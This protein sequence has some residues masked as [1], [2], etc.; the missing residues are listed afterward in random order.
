MF[1]NYLLSD[2]GC[3]YGSETPSQYVQLILR[4][5]RVHFLSQKSLFPWITFISQHQE[6]Q[7]P[8]VSLQGSVSTVL[9]KSQ[10]QISSTKL[11]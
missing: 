2:G 1:F 7:V 6:T 4:C 8:F 3:F 11:T 9:N 10:Q 5:R